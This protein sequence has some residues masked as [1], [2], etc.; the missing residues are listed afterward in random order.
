MANRDDGP[1]RTDAQNLREELEERKRRQAEAAE[2][3]A[4]ARRRRIGHIGAAAAGTVAGGVAVGAAGEFDLLGEIS[5]DGEAA[6]AESDEDAQPDDGAPLLDV[7][8]DLARGRADQA[9]EVAADLMAQAGDTG[10][11]GDVAEAVV[12][13]GIPDTSAPPT[14]G[15]PPGVD[16]PAEPPAGTSRPPAID[17]PGPPAAADEDDDPAIVA[18]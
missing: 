6:A 7:F 10:T 16:A 15:A 13:E 9:R 3:E 11:A 2:D 18:T 17:R 4:G 1:E 8:E 14:P 5:G 12:S